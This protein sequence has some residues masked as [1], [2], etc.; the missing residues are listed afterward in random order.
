LR[1]DAMKKGLERAAHRALLKSL[2]LTDR[3]IAAPWIGVANSWNEIVPGHVHLR[4]VSEAVK[5]GIRKGGA[6]PFE[7]NTIAVCDGLCQG[8]SGMRYSLPSRDLIADSIEVMV[9]AHLFDGVVF[10]PSCDK[11]VPGHLMAAARL[12]IP[13]IFVTGG[14]ML[15]G[16]YKGRDLTLTDMREFVGEVVAGKITERELKR[17]ESVACPGPG[18]CSMM[19]TANTMAATTEA[20]GMSLTGCATTHAVDPEKLVLAEKSGRRIVELWKE[21]VKPSDVMT[22]DAFRNAITVDMALGGSLNTCLHLPAIASELGLK[23]PLDLFDEI[24]ARTPHICPIK[25]AGQYTVK[26]LDEAGGIP[27]VMKE[28]TPLLAADALTVTG[29][30][31]A[32]NIRKTRILRR[33]IIRPLTNPVHKEGSIAVLRGNLAPAGALIKRVAVKEEMLTHRG[34]AKVFNSMEDS[35]AALMKGR[36]ERGDVIVVRYEGPKGGPGMREMHMVTSI[37]VGMGLD[38]TTALVTDGR[39]SGSTRGPAVGHVSPEAAEGGPIAVVEDG[40]LVSYDIPKRRLDVELS[41]SELKARLLR[42]TPPAREGRGYLRRYAKL[43]SS[44]YMGAVLL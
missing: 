34:P 7:F 14:P 11:V 10:I 19:A 17:I 38:T 29:K 2:R 23:I 21:G 1:S 8:T 16:R 13:S 37:L 32:E 25:P 18:S 44:G 42:W 6:T 22:E 43:V 3:E 26:D 20:L 33:E 28:L 30:T 4:E 31:I 39:F 27:A 12:N 15:P 9:E 5:R 40:D 36:V 41:D 35:V 24:S